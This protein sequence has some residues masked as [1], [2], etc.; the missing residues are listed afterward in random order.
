VRRDHLDYPVGREDVGPLAK[1]VDF[2]D[3]DRIASFRQKAEPYLM[4]DEA[5]HNLLLGIIDSVARDPHTY[6]ESRPC[7]AA[8]QRGDD[9]CAVAVMT[10][11]YNLVVSDADDEAVGALIDALVARGIHIPGTVAPVPV[12]AAVAHW[13]Q[14]RTGEAMQRQLRQGVYR[15]TR[16]L[17]VPPVAGKPR[18]ATDADRDLIIGWTA[19]FGAE[20]GDEGTRQRTSTAV[21]RRL[22]DHHSGYL[23]WDADGIAVSLA[24]FGGAT[25]TGIRIGPVYTPVEHRGHGYATAVVAS[26]SQALLESGRRFCF[27][28]TDLANPTSNRIYQR[29]GYQQVCESEQWH[30]APQSG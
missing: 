16:V 14:L 22:S 30:I 28:Y 23:I 1:R 15:L 18:R 24:G 4:R 27:L 2:G 19:A 17:S 21:E 10:P 29:I 12:A 26:L 6:S 3:V 25:P 9:V 7:L 11:P 13:W 8:V 20:L 5:R